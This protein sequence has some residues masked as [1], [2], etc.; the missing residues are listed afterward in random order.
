MLMVQEEWGLVEGEVAEEVEKEVE[1]D[2]HINV[3]IIL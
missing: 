3:R 1:E 2:G